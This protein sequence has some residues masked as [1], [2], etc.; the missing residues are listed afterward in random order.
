ML[1]QQ[2]LCVNASRNKTNEAKKK[3]DYGTEHCQAYPEKRLRANFRLR[4]W[5]NKQK[6][7]FLRAFILNGNR[8][9]NTYFL[10]I[11]TGLDV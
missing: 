9:K 3:P 1:E 2:T 4:V 10:R 7:N 6:R 5:N 11:K 8:K